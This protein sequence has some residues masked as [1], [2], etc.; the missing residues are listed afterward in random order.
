MSDFSTSLPQWGRHPSSRNPGSLP[1][2]TV[3]DPGFLKRG[4]NLTEDA[5]TF[6]MSKRKHR[7]PSGGPPES[8]TALCKFR[9]DWI[10]TALWLGQ[11]WRGTGCHVDPC[12]GY[13]RLVVPV[14]RLVRSLRT[15]CT[16]SAVVKVPRKTHCQKLKG[17]SRLNSDVKLQSQ[18]CNNW[19]FCKIQTEL[20]N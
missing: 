20:A 11:A 3:L 13:A 1:V 6:C 14:I 8:A 4:A 9:I 18:N 12:A 5:V 19:V 10:L 2:Y 7:D 16:C 15:R 17:Y